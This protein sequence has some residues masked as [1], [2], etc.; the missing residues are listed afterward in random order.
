MGDYRESLL[1]M[2]HLDVT[3]PLGARKLG[4]KASYHC[5]MGPYRVRKVRR[6]ASETEKYTGKAPNARCFGLG[7]VTF[8]IQVPFPSFLSLRG[9]QHAR[10]S[11]S[12][13][14]SMNMSMS[15]SMGISMGTGMHQRLTPVNG[16]VE[17]NRRPP[18]RWELETGNGHAPDTF[19]GDGRCAAELQLPAVASV[20]LLASTGR[21]QDVADMEQP[22]LGYADTVTVGVQSV[23]G[24][25]GVESQTEDEVADTY[26]VPAQRN[27]GQLP[28]HG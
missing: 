13:S 10:T 19:P 7:V 26:C 27:D 6:F 14:M 21:A 9:L 2:W 16:G 20:S 3:T 28:S 4:R 24:S 25:V 12:I 1:A 22:S 8:G 18:A 15:I 23:R 11:S 17:P 5:Y